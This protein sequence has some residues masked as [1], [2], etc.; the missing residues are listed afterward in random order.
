MQALNA[1][2]GGVYPFIDMRNSSFERVATKRSRMV[3]MASMGFISAMNLRMIHMRLSVVSSCSRSS[4]RVEES[5]RS[6]AGNIRLLDRERLSWISELPVP[7]N[8]SKITSSILEPVSTRAVAMIVSE[9]PPSMLRAAPKKRLGFC[10][11]L[12][13][14]PPVSTLPEAGATVL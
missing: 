5:T 2:L 14:T 10:R 9:P 8:S 13:S 11:A 7:L 4:R 12:A 6:M 1:V 3:F